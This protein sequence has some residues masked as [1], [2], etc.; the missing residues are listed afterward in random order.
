MK[1]APK[2]ARLVVLENND[3]IS[4]ETV[5]IQSRVRQRA[6]ELSQARP[7]HPLEHYDWIAAESEVISVPPVEMIEKDGRFEVR[8]AIT[9]V[10][11]G[12]VSVMVSPQQLLIKGERSHEHQ[13]DIGTLHFCDFRSATIFRSVNFPEPIN[14]KTVKLEF[15]EG[16]LR[17]SALREGVEPAPPKRAAAKKAAASGSKASPPKRRV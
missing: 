9:G 10:S 1:R 6:F 11:P 4:A 13:T 8:A 12:D 14:L 3:P 17:I 7:H 16:I 2:S 5:A 15:D